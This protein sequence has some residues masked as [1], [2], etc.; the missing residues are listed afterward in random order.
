M[1]Y[2]STGLFTALAVVAVLAAWL[3][4]GARVACERAARRMDAMRGRLIAVESSLDSL[5]RSHRKLSGKFYAELHRA[6][7]EAE[8]RI[9]AAVELDMRRGDGSICENF[10]VAQL[11]GPSSVAA[12]CECDFC[13]RQRE[14]RRA[15]KAQLMPKGQGARVQAMKRGLGQPT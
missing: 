10:K 13:T 8:E 1:Q 4:N 15:L 9:D 6:D 14:L 3:A 5:D 2:L 11:E 7:G 12:S